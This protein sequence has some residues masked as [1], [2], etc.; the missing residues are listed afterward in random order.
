MQK[1][2]D[3]SRKPDY[4]PEFRATNL[5]IKFP[6]QCRHVFGLAAKERSILSTVSF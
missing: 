6:V 3:I 4:R 5:Y 1:R 2:L